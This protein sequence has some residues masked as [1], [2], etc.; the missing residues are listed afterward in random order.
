MIYRAVIKSSHGPSVFHVGDPLFTEIEVW[1]LAICRNWC[2]GQFYHSL[3][4]LF[5]KNITLTIIF[6]SFTHNLNLS[7]W[8]RIAKSQNHKIPALVFVFEQSRRIPLILAVSKILYLPRTHQIQLICFTN[9][10][11]SYIL[12]FNLHPTFVLKD[13]HF[14]HPEKIE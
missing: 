8:K 13:G 12:T 11:C 5:A 14:H 7:E 6:F 10:K 2:L 3:I 4:D 1:Y 9:L